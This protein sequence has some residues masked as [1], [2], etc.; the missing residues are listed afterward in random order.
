MWLARL[1]EEITC[2]R[3]RDPAARSSL[4]VIFCYPG[5]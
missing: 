1:K 4:E 2:I 5:F 3:D